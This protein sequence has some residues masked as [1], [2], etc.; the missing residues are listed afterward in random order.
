MKKYESL[1]FENLK[2]VKTVFLDQKNSLLK[3]IGQVGMQNLRE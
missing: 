1:I 2:D 3:Y